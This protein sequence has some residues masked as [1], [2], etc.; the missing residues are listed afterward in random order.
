MK[1]EEF[2]RDSELLAK[3][4]PSETVRESLGSWMP[5]D[6]ELAVIIANTALP[7]EEKE[8]YLKVLAED[9]DD[10]ALCGQI[11]SFIRHR[12][13][14]FE[15]I[16]K[17]DGAYV[18]VLKDT[19]D[20]YG[21][22]Q[23]FREAK[24]VGLG[25]RKPHSIEKHPLGRTGQLQAM[26][27]LNPFM[28][29][30][31]P[32][33]EPLI[34][35]LGSVY[36]MG[37]IRYNKEGQA[38]DWW[39]PTEAEEALTPGQKVRWDYD[40]ALFPNAFVEL[41]NP[42]EIGDVVRIAARGERAEQY[43]VVLT[44]QEQWQSFFRKVKAGRYA[45]YSDATLVVEF[46]ADD[47]G[48]FVHSHVSPLELEEAGS[49]DPAARYYLLAGRNLILGKGTLEDFCRMGRQYQRVRHASSCS[50]E[51]EEYLLRGRR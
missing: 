1:K 28:A 33:E 49:E 42:F 15:L 7:L 44:S 5:T 46:L 12:Q 20:W 34:R 41:P 40:P 35:C 37:S 8:G 43:G 17:S 27:A 19:E 11:H 38:V 4:I 18:Y 45:D 22:F 30:Q 51:I 26:G 14:A 39:L 10:E 36:C 31:A 6:F 24:E 32:G 29:G 47:Q 23:D 25:L 9:S 16:A 21:L 3:L 2:L 50:A 13:R 48:N